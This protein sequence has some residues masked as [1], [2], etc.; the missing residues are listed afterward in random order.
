MIIAIIAGGSGTRLWPLSQPDYP[1]HLLKLT[2]KNSLLQNTYER[3]QAVANSIYIVTEISHSSE[4]QTQLPDLPADHI[5]IEPARRGTASCIILA[6]A[7]IQTEHPDEDVAFIHADH[8]IVDTNGFAKTVAAACQAARDHRK[9]TL[10]GLQPTYPATGFGYIQIGKSVET[11]NGL[12]VHEA[13]SFKEK[14]DFATAKKYLDSGNYLWNL[15][16]FAAPLP[17]FVETMKQFAPQLYKGYESLSTSTDETREER[18]LALQSQPIDTALIEKTDQILV[19]PGEFDWADIG[20]FLDL[21]KLLKTKKD[22]NAVKG[23]VYQLDCTDSMVHGSTKPIIA[24]GLNGI[25]VIDTPE[26]LL[27]CAKEDSQKVGDL[28][29]QFQAQQNSSK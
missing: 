24:V 25:V 9:I 19:I 12:A 7:T 5:I 17:V 11:I 14:P 28:V 6:L 1:K 26:G 16:L 20:S 23:E 3:A 29:K 10:I 21:H 8:H 13:T 2:G 18:Y 4:V 27:V 15:G 22:G